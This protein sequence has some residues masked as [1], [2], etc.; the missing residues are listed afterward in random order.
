MLSPCVYLRTTDSDRVV[1]TVTQT[2]LD[3]ETQPLSDS[4]AEA[5][6]KYINELGTKDES[7]NVL[8]STEYEDVI[9][10]LGSHYDYLMGV[11]E[12]LLNDFL[13]DTEF[14]YA[15]GN[16][17]GRGFGGGRGDIGNID[18][19]NGELPDIGDFSKLDDGQLPFDNKGGGI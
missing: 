12:R 1:F 17:E 19:D 7:G 5:F 2:D 4:M 16:S 14:P 15:V 18:I 9:Y 6:A 3:T 13:E 11:V 10:H 8:T